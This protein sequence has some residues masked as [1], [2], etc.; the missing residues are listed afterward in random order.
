MADPLLIPIAPEIW[1][2]EG[3]AVPFFTIP[4]PTRMVL[5]RLANGDL[6][7]W[8]P[9]QLH[10]ELVEEIAALGRLHHL[11]APNKLHHLFLSDWAH[12]WPDALLYA[13]PGL[14]RKRS[15]LTFHAALAD[16]PDPAW[17]ADIDQVIFR[18]S[19]ALEEV[20]FF[21]RRSRTLIVCDLIQKLDPAGMNTVHRV[22]MR[23]NSLL[24]PDGSTPREWR[25]S[26]LNR[27]P[28]RAALK[29]A[30]DWDPE[31]IVIAHGTSVES[32]GREALAR[33]LRWLRPEG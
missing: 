4:Y 32:G 30:L 27:R 10:A 9:T 15:D 12:A 22:V 25:L 31:R 11:V 20:V 28:A 6:W 19:F 3:E 2:A 8:S 13:P 5:V 23:L 24:G 14:Q 26:F 17:A 16:V 29:K 7:A 21:H 18:G 1:I 33:S